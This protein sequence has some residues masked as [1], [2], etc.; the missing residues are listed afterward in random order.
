MPLQSIEITPSISHLRRALGA[1]GRGDSVELLGRPCAAWRE[2]TRRELGLSTTRPVIM[3]GHQAAF[4]HPGILAKSFLVDLLA[5]GQA[6]QAAHVVVEQDVEPVASIA[7]PWRDEP[8]PLHR[9][10]PGQ[11]ALHRGAV[12]LLR[13]PPGVATCRLPPFEPAA[14]PARP[15][16]LPGVEE[17]LHRIRTSLMARRGEPN[18]AWQ[19]TRAAFDLLSSSAL[20]PPPTLLS[21]LA[22]LRTELA[23]QLLER[24]AS[25]PES[26]AR[27]Y[28]DAVAERGGAA[29]LRVLP[30]RVELPLWRLDE[31]GRRLRAWDDDL[32]RFKSGAVQLLPRALLMTGLL[33]LAT[34]D[35]FVHGQGGILYDGAMERWF[36]SWLGVEVAPA[37]MATATA[38][39]DFPEANRATADPGAAQLAWRRAWFDPESLEEAGRGEE[40]PRRGGS[41]PAGPGPLKHAHL[42]ELSL[43]PR[44]TLERRRIW[45]AMHEA[46]EGLRERHATALSLRRS[47][48]EDAREHARILPILR[49]REWAFPLHD[50]ALLVALRTA[51]KEAGEG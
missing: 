2:Q 28:N 20:L 39:L 11:P 35:L 33:R 7:A 51:I 25:D 8:G 44:G 3:S 17:G 26:M 40:S 36:A 48:L 29:P 16:A 45:R 1:A 23:R 22:L 18:A 27:H 43:L 41:S 49:D 30:D 6:G 46:L 4:W 42:R 12:E 5:Q 13:Q 19:V 34:C 37:A 10:A 32:E 15:W 21:P 47:A 24:M 50:P 38:T 9:T 14:L 31:A